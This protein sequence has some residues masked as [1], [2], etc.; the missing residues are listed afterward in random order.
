MFSAGAAAAP[1]P[2]R[3]PAAAR[4]SARARTSGRA[5]CGRPPHPQQVN[6]PQRHAR[7]LE[8][9]PGARLRRGGQQLVLRLARTACRCSTPSIARHA[10]HD[11]A[12]V[13]SAMNAAATQD[14]RSTGADA[15]A[16]ERCCTAGRRR[17]R[18]PS[19][20]SSCSRPGAPSGSSRLDR[21]ED[22]TMDAGA[23]PAIMDALYPQLVDA[24]LGAGARPAARRAQG[25]RGRDNGPR[26]RLH[27][28]R[29]QLHRQGPAPA[30]RHAVQ[31]TRSARSFCG[32][33]DLV[34]CRTARLGRARRRRPASSRRAQGTAARTPGSR[35]PPRSGSSSRPGLLPTTIRYTNRPSGIQQVHLV[36][37]APRTAALS[38]RISAAIARLSSPLR[39]RRT[40]TREAVLAVSCARW[41]TGGGSQP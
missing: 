27:R 19:A 7:E 9:Q 12:S 11:L 1:R 3:R 32:G 13:T 40:A 24:V 38:G 41:G 34:A 5:S 29:D 39:R 30:A 15:D 17:A 14:L 4:R 8:Q 2:A 31:A 23:A 16:H 37:G 33:G 6:P 28:R 21:D 18:A 22:G 35:T 36:Q 26:L 25:A 20:C 10:K